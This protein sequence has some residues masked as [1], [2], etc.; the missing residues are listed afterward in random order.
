[1]LRWLILLA[2][3]C[4]L[5]P[6][7]DLVYYCSFLAPIALII[8]VNSFI[9]IRIVIVL[10]KPRPKFA[11]S[12]SVYTKTSVRKGQIQGSLAVMV[13]LGITWIFGMLA[14]SHARI[15]FQYIFCITNS[16][17]GFFIFVFR[18]VN[19][20]EVRRAWKAFFLSGSRKPVRDSRSTSRSN[21][22][23]GVAVNSLK[24]L[25]KPNSAFN[26]TDYLSAAA[27][28]MVERS[29]IPTPRIISV[30]FMNTDKT[31]DMIDSDEEG[32]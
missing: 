6:H 21:V 16:L 22:L 18:C 23:D 13:L 27:R 15:V 7:N 2:R 4:R 1:M 14:V 26:G 30:A 29:P 8:L 12:V 11:N 10:C 19:R 32:D 9:F 24:R 25:S 31:F 28:V 17:Q 5:T 3:R 20:P